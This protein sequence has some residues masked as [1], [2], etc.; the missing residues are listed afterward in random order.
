MTVEN[1]RKAIL[2]HQGRESRLF[3]LAYRAST[4]P[5]ERCLSAWF[6]GGRY[7]YHD[8]LFGAPQV[9]HPTTGF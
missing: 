1:V 6:S 8:L 7:V 2:M 4:R 3:L 9:R 5:Q